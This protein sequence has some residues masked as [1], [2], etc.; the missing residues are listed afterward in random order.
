MNKF[1]KHI[2]IISTVLLLSGLLSS[3]EQFFNPD[4]KVNITEDQLYDDWYEFRA[5][6]IGLYALQQDLVEQL[7]VLG[8]LRGDLLTV[9]E[10]ADADLRE[11]Y[12]FNI[13]KDNKYASPNNFFKLIAATNRFI[14][15][16]ENTYPNVLDPTVE[17]NNYDR[18]YGEAL[19][20]RAWAYFN[21]VRIYGKVPFID[22]QLSSIDQINEFIN[23]SS[24]FP[25]DTVI[26]YSIDGYYNDTIVNAGVV[27]EKQYFDT[28]MT[29]RYFTH[30]LENKVKA[31][32]VNHY[33]ENQDNSWEVTVWSQWSYQTLL[34]HMYLSLG[35]LAKSAYYLEQVLYNNTDNDRYQLDRSFAF[36]SW[37]NIFSNVDSRE[38][39]YTLWFGKTNQQQNGLQNL[40]QNWGASEYM[41]KPTAQAVHNW[42]TQWRGHQIRYDYSLLDSTR[43][44][45]PGVP[46]DFYRGYGS[47]YLYVSNEQELEF[48]DLTQMLEYKRINEYR[49]V[50]SIMENMDTVVFKYSINSF[51]YDNDPNFIIYR[52]GGINLYLAEIYNYWNYEDDNGK[53]SSYTQNALNIINNGSNYNEKVSRDQLGV[54]GRVGLGS[55]ESAFKITNYYFLTDPFTNQIIGHRNLTGNLLAKQYLLE[56]QIMDE[57]AREL[58]FE[59]ERYYD[60]MRVAKRRGD[61]SFLAEKISKKYPEGMRET[62]YNKLLD[63]NNWYINYFD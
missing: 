5:A 56:E 22:Y 30:E 15:I 19:C 35:D 53:V 18:L 45:E 61:P 57:R 42:E 14:S 21:A 12:N 50:Y 39:I 24:T 48:E 47:S 55:G 26:N 13:S 37:R 3:C 32:G 10:N 59:G 52:A 49:S 40:F 17:V 44:T 27:L 11:I 46:N 4:Q 9:T 16:L 2:L 41:L 31:V 60:L 43:T 1:S 33:I 6:A 62:V 25:I 34:G 36:N 8:E 54:R 29:I 23:S 51:Y 7:V 28:D 20:M 38:H 58:A 63:E